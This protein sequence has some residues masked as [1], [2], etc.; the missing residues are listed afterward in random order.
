[1]ECFWRLFCYRQP[2]GYCTQPYPAIFYLYI[3]ADH[4]VSY[5]YLYDIGFLEKY[6]KLCESDEEKSVVL[7]VNPPDLPNA[8]AKASASAQREAIY[9]QPLRPPS[10]FPQ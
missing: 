9:A 7:P 5:Y 8:C 4:G 1:M 6:E 3:L 10:D 2:H